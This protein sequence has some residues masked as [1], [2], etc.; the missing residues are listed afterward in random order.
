MANFSNLWLKA[1]EILLNLV[2][3]PPYANHIFNVFINIY[4]YANYLIC[5][6]N[7]GDNRPMSKL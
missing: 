5:I 4:D 7:K 2:R 1:A 3:T 6:C